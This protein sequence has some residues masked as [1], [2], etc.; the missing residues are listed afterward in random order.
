MSTRVQELTDTQWSAISVFFPIQRKRKLDLKDVVDAILYMVRTGCQWRNLPNCYPKW[1]AVQYYFERWKKAGILERM[2]LMLNELDRERCEKSAKA[3]TLCI[4]T[5][6]IKL[7]PRVYED[8]GFDA[9]KKVNGRKRQILTDSDGRIMQVRVHAANGHDG[10]EGCLLLDK[11]AEDWGSQIKRIN[12]DSSYKGQ[13]AD[14]VASLGFE[15][16]LGVR[17]ESTKGFVPIKVR[18]VVERTISW[19]NF[20][21]RI[22]KDY[23]HTVL[24]SATWILLA[25]ITI[26]LQRNFQNSE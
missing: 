7:S 22:V 18:W 2:N 15:F 1:T 19:T 14:K 16:V 24:S 23:E 10:I 17:P 20:F 9:N 26:M 12:G 11:M 4:D 8:R 13:F 21:R 5:Q 3:S 6:S 25:N